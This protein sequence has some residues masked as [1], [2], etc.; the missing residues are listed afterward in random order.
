VQETFNG[1]S[2]CSPNVLFSKKNQRCTIFLFLS[3]DF[4]F[5]LL[6]R[7][8]FKD[9][10][11]MTDRVFRFF[12]I[13][14]APKEV[15]P[16]V[17]RPPNI[18]RLLRRHMR[19]A[20]S[21]SE[22]AVLSQPPSPFAMARILHDQRSMPS[23]HCA[24]PASK[25]ACSNADK[26]CTEDHMRPEDPF[27]EQESLE[28]AATFRNCVLNV[29]EEDVQRRHAGMAFSMPLD[30]PIVLGEASRSPVPGGNVARRRS[31]SVHLR[32]LRRST[33]GM[34]GRMDVRAID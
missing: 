19:D 4:F 14:S 34:S 1:T 6:F 24:P 17:G 8:S 27:G 13:S 25:D 11:C 32:R 28:S 10:E 22:Y 5:L 30:A 7:V 2:Y 20:I 15:P 12:R 26:P 31:S 23:P 18:D 33:F 21:V 29:L 9:T 3:L 16:E